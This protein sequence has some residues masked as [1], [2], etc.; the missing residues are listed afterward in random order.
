MNLNIYYR[1]YNGLPPVTICSQ[2]SPAYNLPFYLFQKYFNITFHLCLGLQCGFLPSH[3]ST[4]TLY[5]FLSTACNVPD[6]IIHFYFFVEKIFDEEYKQRSSPLCDSLHYP[7]TS[8][9]LHVHI[10]LNNPFLNTL[11]LCEILLG[12]YAMSTGTY[13]RKP[14]RNK[15]S[16]FSGAGSSIRFFL[17]CW[18]MNMEAPRSSETSTLYQ[19]IRPNIPKN[20]SIYPQVYVIPWIWVSKFHTPRHLDA[21]CTEFMIYNHLHIFSY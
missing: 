1:V 21:Q 13:L 18:T 8:T 16:P 17:D 19:S 5:A 11:L 9:M 20:L 4:K 6:H 15:M 12:Y 2:K 7:P 10:L 3:F 14:R